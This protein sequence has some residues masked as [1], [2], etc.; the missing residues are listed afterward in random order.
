[1]SDIVK[2]LQNARPLGIDDKTLLHDA[3]TEIH[4]LRKQIA[5]TPQNDAK[6]WKETARLVITN[7]IQGVKTKPHQEGTDQTIETYL[8]AAYNTIKTKHKN[9]T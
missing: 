9:N 1:M 2:R 7:L 5:E 8:Q 3:I 6:I 4:K